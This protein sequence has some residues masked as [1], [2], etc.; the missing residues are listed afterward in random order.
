MVL[1]VYILRGDHEV[2]EASLQLALLMSGD[3]TFL[4]RAYTPVL[5][6][7]VSVVSDAKLKCHHNR[8]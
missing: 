8:S 3:M 5:L 6:Q 1:N 4:T 2:P 7:S